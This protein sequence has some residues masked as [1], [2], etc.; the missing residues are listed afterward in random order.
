MG[1][2]Y[3]NAKKGR[4]IERPKGHFGNLTDE[5]RAAQALPELPLELEIER[6]PERANCRGPVARTYGVPRPSSTFCIP[7]PPQQHSRSR[8]VRDSSV[9]LG[10]MRCVRT[11]RHHQYLLAEAEAAHEIIETGIGAQWIELG[12]H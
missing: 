12:T 7:F 5:L 4:R 1:C 2:D 8:S 10:G 9:H 6:P 3:Y 11:P